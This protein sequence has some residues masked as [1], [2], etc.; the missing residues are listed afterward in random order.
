[1]QMSVNK[2]NTISAILAL[3]LVVVCCSENTSYDL[4][5]EPAIVVDGQ[6]ELNGYPKVFLTRNIPYYVQIDSADLQYL[7]LKQAKITVSDGHQSEILTLKFNKKEFPPYYYQGNEIMGKAG[8]TYSLTIEYGEKTLTATTTIPAPVFLDTAWFQVNTPGDSLGKIHAILPDKAG[9]HN[10][11][12]TLT[13]IRNR[14]SEFYPTLISVFDDQYFDG[15]D[16]IF[17]LNKGPETY[18]DINTADF[19]YKKGDTITLK[20]CTLDKA[21]HAFWLSYQNEVS[22]GANPFA[23]S[24]HKVE[25]NITGGKGIWGGMGSTNYLL[26]AQ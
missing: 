12:R 7:V 24:F 20:I 10:Y 3:L 1:M 9:E 14:Q 16:Y 6:I 25:S 22:N 13:R 8:K 2:F 17:H 11:Y 5:Y 15:L 4:A 26:V 19:F 18:L 23:S 21:H